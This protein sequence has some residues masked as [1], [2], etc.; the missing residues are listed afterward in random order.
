MTIG[1]NQKFMFSKTDDRG[2]NFSVCLCRVYAREMC[3]QHYWE[4]PLYRPALLGISTLPHGTFRN[5]HFTARWTEKGCF[6]ICNAPTAV[7]NQTL[8]AGATKNL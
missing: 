8:S 3:S 6:V 7:E 5:S 4:F 1:C 2:M